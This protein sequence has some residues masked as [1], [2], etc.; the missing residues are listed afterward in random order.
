[1]K[2]LNEGETLERSALKSGMSETTA[3]RYRKGAAPKGDRPRRTYRTRTD[4]FAEVWAE[5][6][7]MLEGAPGLEAKTIFE[8]LCERPDARFTDGQLRTLQR[9]IRRWRPSRGPEK[10]VMFPQEHRPG[11]AA[12]SDFTVMNELGITLG[13]ETFD[14]MLFHMVLPYSNWEAASICFSESFESLVSGLQGA[15]WQI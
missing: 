7:K 4:A 10:E 6:E 14:H 15:L 2:E 3:R 11:E 9:K 1:M 12:Q 8:R 13:G 5:I